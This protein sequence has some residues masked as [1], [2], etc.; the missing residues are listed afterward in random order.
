[1][2]GAFTH[3]TYMHSTFQ[4]LTSNHVGCKTFEVILLK[5]VASYPR[6]SG[7]EATLE[8]CSLY[9]CTLECTHDFTLFTLRYPPVHLL[10]LC[11]L[12]MIPVVWTQAQ[13][14]T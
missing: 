12:R 3:D 5:R 14:D 6:R 13:P 8:H 9:E 4:D 1:M 11:G 7:Y 10:P 2:W